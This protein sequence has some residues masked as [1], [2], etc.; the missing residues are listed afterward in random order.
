[1]ILMQL[2]RCTISVMATMCVLILGS[3]EGVTGRLC[4]VTIIFMAIN[5]VLWKGV[6]R[7]ADKSVIVKRLFFGDVL[8]QV[9]K[10]IHSE[11]FLVCTSFADFP[12]TSHKSLNSCKGV[13]RSRDLANCPLV[14]IIHFVD[15]VI[16]VKRIITKR[17]GKEVPTNTLI[18]TFDIPNTPT[19]IKA[20]Y[21]NIPVLPY[22]PN[23]LRCFTCQRFGH[24][25]NRYKQTVKCA[26]CAE[27][28]HTDQNCSQAYKCVNCGE[29]H[30]DY[31]KDCRACKCEY[32]TQYIKTTKNV[33]FVEARNEYVKVG[34][35]SYLTKIWKNFF[36]CI[37]MI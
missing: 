13:I 29:S 16:H 34:C 15:N 8:L 37:T 10:Q 19:Y 35:G 1:M 30:P 24:A 7:M 17:D 31:K 14:Q 3:K 32:Q 5:N 12:V 9:L 20:G 22:I 28:G 33:S 36:W 18:L 4:N 6:Q 26:C 25:S 21:L 23:P 2:T 27:E 11:A